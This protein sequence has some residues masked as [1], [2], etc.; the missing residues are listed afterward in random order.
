MAV[1]ARSHAPAGDLAGGLRGI[2]HAARVDE[3]LGLSEERAVLGAVSGGSGG[4]RVRN[5]AEGS[6]RA[7]VVGGGRGNGSSDGLGAVVLALLEGGVEGA[8]FVS[9]AVGR[10]GSVLEAATE[11]ALGVSPL[12]SRVVLADSLISVG[13]ANALALGA[14]SIPAAEFVAVAA[15]LCGVSEEAALAAVS[16]GFEDAHEGFGRALGVVEE[17]A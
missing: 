4:R 17:P 16:G 11:G 2:P 15:V 7:L 10:V 5:S 14:L 3:T 13:S 6:G 8:E 1:D 12:A 9:I